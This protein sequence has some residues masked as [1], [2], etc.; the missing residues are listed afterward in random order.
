MYR[1]NKTFQDVTISHGHSIFANPEGKARYRKKIQEAIDTSAG[2]VI[3][4][5]RRGQQTARAIL[6]DMG[7]KSQGWAKGAHG[8][9]VDLL[10]YEAK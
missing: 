6:K 4:T 1:C 3:A 2:V 7:F 8:E 9:D 10:I 5:V